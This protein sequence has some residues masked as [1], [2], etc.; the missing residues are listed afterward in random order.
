MKIAEKIAAFHH[1]LPYTI[2]T[3][4]ILTPEPF[5]ARPVARRPRLLQHSHH[6]LEITSSEPNN[7]KASQPQSTEL[8]G[9][10]IQNSTMTVLKLLLTPKPQTNTHDSSPSKQNKCLG[11]MVTAAE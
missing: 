6:I 3:R 5:M 8:I 7:P 1:H 9:H 2:I 4:S 11:H 10:G